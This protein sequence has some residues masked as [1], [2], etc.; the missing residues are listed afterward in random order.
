MA[1]SAAWCAGSAFLNSGAFILSAALNPE[2]RLLMWL[3]RSRRQ[4]PPRRAGRPRCA[5]SLLQPAIAGVTCCQGLAA[6]DY[7]NDRRSWQELLMLPQSVLFPP[8]RAGRSTAR[9]QLP[10]LCAARRASAALGVSALPSPPRLWTALCRGEASWPQPLAGKGL[11]SVLAALL[12]AGLLPQ[13]VETARALEA[14]H[15]LPQLFLHAKS[16]AL[17]GGLCAGQQRQLLGSTCRCRLAA[18][19]A[20]KLTLVLGLLHLGPPQN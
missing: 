18:H 17:A 12:S 9:R 3:S 13:T 4:R 7:R 2:P 20:M 5:T 10:S 11:T 6:V 14:L 15:P 16:S 19:S 8:P 1:K